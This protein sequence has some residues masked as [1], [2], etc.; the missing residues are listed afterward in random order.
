MSTA[1]D[2]SS[3]YGVFCLA[4]TKVAAWSMSLSE[5]VTSRV[6]EG[7]RN[8]KHPHRKLHQSAKDDEPI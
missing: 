2:E 4:W 6:L 5:V 7:I 3:G 1:D 8:S